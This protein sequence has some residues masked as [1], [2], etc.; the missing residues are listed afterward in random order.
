MFCAG[1]H[2]CNRR[3]IYWKGF[4]TSLIRIQYRSNVEQTVYFHFFP[5]LKANISSIRHANIVTPLLK[6]S[7]V[8]DMS[9][10]TLICL[11]MMLIDM[12]QLTKTQVGS[13]HPD[14][15]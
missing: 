15:L 2:N 6:H 9:S 13:V 10:I 5:N 11:M 1:L 8:I 7:L 4:S 14:L 12:K 3:F